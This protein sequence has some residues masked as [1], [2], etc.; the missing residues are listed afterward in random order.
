MYWRYIM[1]NRT[2]RV[3]GAAYLPGPE[4]AEVELTIGSEVVYA[5]EI[6]TVPEN[7][8]TFT[9]FYVNDVFD[10]FN[11]TADI[12]LTGEMPL[13]LKVVKGS[14]FFQQIVGNYAGSK[15]DTVVEE[16][17]AINVLIQPQDFYGPLSAISAV[18]DGRRN[19]KINGV[20]R[21]RSTEHNGSLAWVV[22]AGQTLTCDL[23]I[24]PDLIVTHIPT[25]EELRAMPRDEA[26]ALVQ[27]YFSMENFSL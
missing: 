16:D 9:G 5:G 6:N 4:K 23:F 3:T 25:M 22:H 15:I 13:T 18:D 10:L 26:I 11:F 8:P 20:L 17:T 7:F 1:I 14:L 2:F 21:P 19:V 27:K 24:D 12:G